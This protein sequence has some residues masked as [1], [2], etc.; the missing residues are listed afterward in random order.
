[1]KCRAFGIF[2][3][4]FF[5]KHTFLCLDT[6]YSYAGWP[7]M[8]LMVQVLHNLGLLQHEHGD[9]FFNCGFIYLTFELLPGNNPSHPQVVYVPQSR[10]RVPCK[11]LLLI[12]RGHPCRS[13]VCI[14]VEFLSLKFWY[15]R[16]KIMNNGENC[17]G[18]CL[19]WFPRS[20]VFS[21]CPHWSNRYFKT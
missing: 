2:R 7:E 4:E 5:Q 18:K 6:D 16:R 14:W 17:L 20:R 13:T 1:M 21:K 3:F 12:L 11:Y 10:G 8:L 9:I 19:K 15:R